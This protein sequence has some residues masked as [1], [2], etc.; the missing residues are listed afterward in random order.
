LLEG[1][2]FPS[3]VRHAPGVR[4]TAA[5]AKSSPPIELCGVKWRNWKMMLKELDT[6]TGE[7]K[8][9]GILRFYDLSR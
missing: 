1:G 6:A 7:V 8:T 4:L 2:N 9:Y 5:S 3:R